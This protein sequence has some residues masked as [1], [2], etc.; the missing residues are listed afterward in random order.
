M[1]QIFSLK[2]SFIVF[3]TILIL[4]SALVL[5]A[6]HNLTRSTEQLINAKQQHEYATGLATQYKSL[7]EAM[8]RDVM[9]FVAT[10]QPE[11]HDSYKHLTAVLHGQAPDKAGLQQAMIDRFRD[12]AFTTEELATLES[13]HQQIVELAKTEIEAISTAKGEF[14]DG[15]G[16]VRIALPN[17]LMA[18]VMIFGQHYAQATADIVGTI[19]NFDA[20]QSQRLAHDVDSASAASALAY[21]I[22]VGAIAALLGISA[23]ALW[24]LYR[25]IKRPLDEG[26]KL[27]QELAEGRLGASVAVR[28]NDELGKLLI[29]LNGIGEGLRETI[30]DVGERAA[31]MAAASHQIA[32]GN[33]DLSQRTNEQAANV[34]ET[35]ASMSQLATTVQNNAESTSRSQAL[36][37]QAAGYA[38]RGSQVVQ[39]AV[40]NMRQI[41]QD[42]DKVADITGVIKSIAFQTNILALNAAVEAA[43]AG[44]HG[45]GFAVVAAEVRSLALRSADASR[46]IEALIA[47]TVAQLDAGATLI[48]GAGKAMDEIVGSVNEVQGIMA[49]IA[50]ASQEQA[51]GIGEVTVAVGHLDVI[52]QRNRD[53]VQEAAQATHTQQLEADHLVAALARFTLGDDEEAETKASEEASTF[54]VYAKLAGVGLRYADPTYGLA[55]SGA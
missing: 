45:R 31:R 41:C 28:R 7:T 40:R 12:A 36:V 25:S 48:D 39:E 49:S 53:L 46:E 51:M 4:L 43:R 27:A 17:A 29:A 6:I 32:G 26:V 35:A 9:A 24:S 52:T 8:T 47:G 37:I 42:S 55:K 21:R 11:F 10:E 16:G 38:D 34:Q 23:L 5:S 44:A 50:M 2:K 19:D 33:M 18:K 22:A 1:K 30:R 15:Q 14:D 54:E 20:M 13:A 3:L